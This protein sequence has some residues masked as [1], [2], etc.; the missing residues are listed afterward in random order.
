M[1][2]LKFNSIKA[3][4]FTLALSGIVL[5]SCDSGKKKASETMDE[6]EETTEELTQ[7]A[8]AKLNRRTLKLK[9][10]ET[11]T[12]NFDDL[13]IISVKGWSDYSIL[14]SEVENFKKM[15]YSTTRARVKKLEY[16]VSNLEKSI[17][18][19]LRT[20][21]LLEDAREVK[22]EYMKMINDTDLSD[23]KMKDN[24]EEFSDEFEDFKKEM[25]ETV[26]KYREIH[27]DAIE[28]YNEEMQDGEVDDAIE[29][30]N[31]E[32]KEIEKM[33]ENKQ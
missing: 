12:Y 6:I 19:W 26:D 30:Y 5:T 9:E 28:E 20:E 32:I 7:E 16:T 23:E 13:G 2:K 33:V 8:E 25:N 29:E 18:K 27:K 15:D 14:N 31:E 11:I 24:L 22:E 17:P 1:R 21:E 4:V 3:F 10:G